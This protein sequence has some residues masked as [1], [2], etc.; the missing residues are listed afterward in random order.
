MAVD[1]SDAVAAVLVAALATAGITLSRVAAIQPIPYPGVVPALVVTQSDYQ[2][3]MGNDWRRHP[4]ATFTCVLLLARYNKDLEASAAETLFDTAKEA[5]VT[6]FNT[7]TTRSVNH[8]IP[9]LN[10]IAVKYDPQGK[11][12]SWMGQT[13]IGF[14]LTL[15]TIGLVQRTNT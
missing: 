4:T 11:Y 9:G 2:S 14:Y 5:V 8:T 12:I 15:G 6:A 1:N 13:F 3:V 10:R 7:L